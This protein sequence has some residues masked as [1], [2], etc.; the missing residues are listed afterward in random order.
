VRLAGRW[1]ELARTTGFIE[2]TLLADDLAFVGRWGVDWVGVVGPAMAKPVS[3]PPMCGS[4]AVSPDGRNVV[5]FD[6]EVPGSGSHRCTR[7]TAISYDTRG[8]EIARWQRDL[9]AK[10][11]CHVGPLTRVLFRSDSSAVL[12]VGCEGRCRLLALPGWTTMAEREGIC[13]FKAPGLAALRLSEGRQPL[14]F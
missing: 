8:A 1:Q 12:A 6:C 11:A 13:A 7:A 2:V 9:P 5:C 4:A 14:D 10:E 3:L